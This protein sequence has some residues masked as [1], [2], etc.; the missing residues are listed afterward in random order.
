MTFRCNN[1]PDLPS[2]SKSWRTEGNGTSRS[3]ARY[4]QSFF[5]SPDG[6]AWAPETWKGGEGTSGVTTGGGG[7]SW[8]WGGLLHGEIS[9]KEVREGDGDEMSRIWSLSPG[10]PRVRR[11]ETARRLISAL[12]PRPSPRA[13]SSPLPPRPG[14]PSG[15]CFCPS[16]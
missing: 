9:E 8:L 2:L 5:C 4:L 16:G 1:S 3:Q 7:G 10:N 6:S 11:R 12:A 14:A 13:P 15:T